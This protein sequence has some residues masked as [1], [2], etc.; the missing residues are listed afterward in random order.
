[1]PTDFAQLG[2]AGAVVVVV[3]FFLR[4]MREEAVK[5]D[6]T[7]KEVAQ[8]LT[9][10]S[11]ATDKN[12]QATKS[13]DTYLKQR[14]GRDIEKHHELLVATQAIPTAL[15]QIADDQAA[16]IIQAVNVEQNVTKQH[17]ETQ[18]VE[19]HI[20]DRRTTGGA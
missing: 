10:L 12:T 7:Y 4:F 3:W 15:K 14:N 17:V 9:K 19:Q 2:P 18:V 16:A 20:D 6:R 11:V 5:R 13:A 1:M 8:A